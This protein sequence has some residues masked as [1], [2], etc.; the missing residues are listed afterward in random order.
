MPTHHFKESHC[1]QVYKIKQKGH[2]QQQVQELQ[3]LL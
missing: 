1:M 3:L 2:Q